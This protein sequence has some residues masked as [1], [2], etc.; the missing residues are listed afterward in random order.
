MDIATQRKNMVE[1]Q[2]RPSDVTDRRIIR[3]MLDLPRELFVPEKICSVAYMDGP[4]SLEAAGAPGRELLPPRTEA[5]LLQSAAISEDDAVLIVG[6]ATG[7]TAALAAKL[8]KS[9]IALEVNESLA[10]QASQALAATGCKNVS[11]V[12]GSLPDGWHSEAPYNV[13]LVAGA[14]PGSPDE[15]LAQLK[16]HG[17]LV[18]IMGEGPS[19]KAQVWTRVALQVSANPAFDATAPVLPGFE[20]VAQ[21][22]L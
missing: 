2:V 6:A 12:T 8:A 9:V 10:E 3:A 5:K 15:L 19:S 11:V 21:F 4:L 18:A 22:A 20:K 14:I 7:Y 17:R 1:S 13:V 16:D